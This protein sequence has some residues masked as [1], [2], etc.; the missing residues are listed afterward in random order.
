MGKRLEQAFLVTPHKRMSKQ[1]ASMTK[2]HY[3]CI[4]E[5][6]IQITVREHHTHSPM[7][8]IKKTDN[9]YF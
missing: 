6:Q 4:R 9:Y 3:I 1:P 2:D 7:A 5:L 8:K